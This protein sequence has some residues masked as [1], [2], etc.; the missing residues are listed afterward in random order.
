[1]NRTLARS[2]AVV[3]VLAAALAA[4]SREHEVPRHPV[5]PRPMTGLGKAITAQMDLSARPVAPSP[6][7]M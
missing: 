5:S 3:A 4:C 2:L 1:M 6:G 7:W